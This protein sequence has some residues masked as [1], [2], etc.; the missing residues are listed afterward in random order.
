MWVAGYGRFSSP[1][2]CFIQCLIDSDSRQWKTWQLG[3]RGIGDTIR[4]HLTKYHGDEWRREVYKH[5]L[6]G[7]EHYNPDGS[8]KDTHPSLQHQPNIDER[9]PFTIEGFLERLE[10]FAVADDQVGLLVHFL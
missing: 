7:W 4:D 6:K 8:L 3:S 5:Q 9:E 1:L 10:R 2:S